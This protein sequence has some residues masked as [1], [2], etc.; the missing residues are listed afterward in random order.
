M[1]KTVARNDGFTVIILHS[2]FLTQHSIPKTHLCATI[3]LKT[4]P[5]GG[6]RHEERGERGIFFI[7]HFSNCSTLHRISLAARAASLDPRLRS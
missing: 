4:R 2:Q 1:T 6:S 5:K 7:K 3:A